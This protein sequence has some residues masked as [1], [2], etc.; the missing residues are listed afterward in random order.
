MEVSDGFCCCWIFR[1]I[2]AAR[3]DDGL[4]IVD[5]V[6]VFVDD[7][8]VDKAPQAFGGLEFGT[9]GRQ[10]DEPYAFGDIEAGLAVPS[11]IVEN[12]DDDALAAPAALP[13][14]GVEQ[15]LKHRL[16]HAV[17]NIP[18]RLAAGRRDEGGDIELRV[19]HA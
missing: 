14:E 6:E 11:G 5:C 10:V 7:W 8:F 2:D 16:G 9:V 13:G 3:F 19:D 15:R 12:E 1:E 17:A 4:Q 18:D